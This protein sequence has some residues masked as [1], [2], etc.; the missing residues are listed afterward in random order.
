MRKFDLHMELGTH[1]NTMCKILGGMLLA[2][3]ISCAKPYNPKVVASPN[4][5][6][7]VEGTINT[8]SDSTIVKLSRTV[9]VNSATTVNPVPDATVAIQDDQNGSY[10]LQSLNNGYYVTSGLNLGNAHKYR[11]SITTTDGKIYLSDYVSP[12]AS[13]PIDS[14]GFTIK[15]TGAQIY[16]NTHDPKNSTHYYRWD[17]TETWQ[18]HADYD[19]QY[20]SNGTNI[21]LRTAAQNI[22][23][24]YGNSISNNILL[25]SSAK[26]SQ[27]VIYQAPITLIPPTSEKIEQRYSIKIKQYAIT[28]DA[29][30]Y[31]QILK[32]NT[33]ELGS[34][35]D[36]Q[37]SQLTGNIHCTTDATLPVIGYISAGT[38]QQKR[39]FFNTAQ[40]PAT[41]IPTYPY[42][43]NIDT[44]YFSDKSGIDEVQEYL[45]PIPTSSIPLHL[46]YIKGAGPFGYVYSDVTCVDCTIRGTL[47][48]PSFWQ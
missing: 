24:C 40:F 26:L 19:S 14:I 32:Q 9:N 33:E 39:V 1:V 13:P 48:K 42:N 21:V 12:V 16:V 35:F 6:L 2:S 28:Q 41:W 43:C 47:T 7:V 45:V 37:P 8:G 5:Y 38:I 46:F 22:Y 10:S 30:N 20:I 25:G 31:F 4:N 3:F 18:F 36:A 34:I 17:Y 23:Q 44:S 29:Y 11:L 15:N 27:D